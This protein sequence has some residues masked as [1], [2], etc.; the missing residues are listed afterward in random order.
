MGTLTFPRGAALFLGL[1]LSA[2]SLCADDQQQ[3]PSAQKPTQL[4]SQTS[5]HKLHV[6]KG[7]R[8]DINAIGQRDIVG[9]DF[10]SLQK[11]IEL[12]KG[13]SKRAEEH[14]KFL[15]DLTVNEYINRIG[16]LLVQNSDAKIPVTIKV[17]DSEEISAFSV[18]GG[19]LYVNSAMILDCQ[20]EAELAGVMAHAIAHLAARHTTRMWTREQMAQ[21]LNTPMI[22]VIG[23]HRSDGLGL[24]IP[25]TMMKYRRAFEMEADY[26]GIQYLYKSGY[27]PAAFVARLDRKDTDHIKPGSLEASFAEEPLPAERI[28]AAKE[29][30]AGILPPSDHLIVNTPEFDSIKASLK[31]RKTA[32]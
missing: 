2:L 21:V 30:I 20:N 26:F 7:G 11:E 3:E 6:K 28:A 13:E 29:E 8:D 24:I 16:Q 4:Q 14:I 18:V 25:L 9:R 27:D 12:G 22:A 32:Q 10:Y 31:Q 5:A 19:Y 1:A 15:D 23:D 17:A